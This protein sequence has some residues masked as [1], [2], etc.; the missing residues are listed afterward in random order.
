[1]TAIDLGRRERRSYIWDRHP[2]D[3]YVEPSWFS[4]RLFDA[5]IFVGEVIDPCCGSGNIVRSARA[6]HLPA[7]GWDIGDPQGRWRQGRHSRCRRHPPRARVR[8]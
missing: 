6:R 5:E 4:E 3:F 8:A 7:A 2:D 1:M